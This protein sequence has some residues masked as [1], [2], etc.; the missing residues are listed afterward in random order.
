MTG[1]TASATIL[2]IAISVVQ[3]ISSSSAFQ[4]SSLSART[5]NKNLSLRS[6][7]SQ[8]YQTPST[9]QQQHEEKAD[10]WKPTVSSLSD[11]KQYFREQS[12]QSSE[13]LGTLGFHHVEFYAGDAL[14]TAK[15]FELAL[16]IPITCW[17]SLATGN[18]KCVT[19]GLECGV[20]ND[21]EVEPGD[22]VRFLITAPLSRA[23]QQQQTNSNNG[24]A[25]SNVQMLSL[26]HI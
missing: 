22:G 16:G 4:L 1:R 24:G 5:R 21:N 15:R 17:S 11:R 3:L 14:M 8:L 19:Y 2:L 26:I 10:A 13:H 25:G 6:T 18:D 23:M 7:S 20:G 12:A 9:Q